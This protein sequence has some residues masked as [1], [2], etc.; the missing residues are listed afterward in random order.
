MSEQRK[1]ERNSIHLGDSLQVM[2]VMPE[3]PPSQASA[4]TC[5]HGGSLRDAD[6]LESGLCIGCQTAEWPARSTLRAVTK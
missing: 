4:A 5:E 3:V 1:F 2:A 6:A